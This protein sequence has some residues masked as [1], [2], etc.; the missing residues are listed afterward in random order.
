MQ[1]LPSRCPWRGQLPSPSSLTCKIKVVRP[2]IIVK[3]KGGV[4]TVSTT[5]YV[6]LLLKSLSGVCLMLILA[7]DRVALFLPEE[8]K[9]HL[10]CSYA[11]GICPT[12]HLLS[13]GNNL[14]NLERVK[15]AFYLKLH[16]Q[17]GPQV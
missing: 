11:R 9:C 6:G 14:C 17:A 16:A 1:P 10:I 13:F 4:Q 3:C 8:N 12:G 7:L 5:G 15:H 2:T